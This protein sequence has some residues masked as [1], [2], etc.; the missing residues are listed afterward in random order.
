MKAI[1]RAW[2]GFSHR[3]I[4]AQNWFLAASVYVTALAPVALVFKVIGKK[5]VSP[6]TPSVDEDSYFTPVQDPQ[7]DM[8][9]AERMF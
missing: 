2:K 6:P 9:R 5:L 4:K 7:L 1:W 3:L 8:K